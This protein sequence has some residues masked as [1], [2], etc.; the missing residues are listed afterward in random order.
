VFTENKHDR[1]ISPRYPGGLGKTSDP[2][3][4]AQKTLPEELH[5]ETKKSGGGNENKPTLDGVRRHFPKMTKEEG[6]LKGGWQ[7]HAQKKRRGKK[8]WYIPKE[9][10]TCYKIH[11]TDQRLVGQIAH[12]R[13][14]YQRAKWWHK[15]PGEAKKRPS[16]VKEKGV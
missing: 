14:D 15:A 16:D 12:R 5:W 7:R 11:A 8:G 1:S 2:F 3:N 4:P 6:E 13:V 9:S 10:S